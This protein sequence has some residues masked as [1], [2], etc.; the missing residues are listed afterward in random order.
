ML[1]V[2]SERAIPAV[3]LTLTVLFG[4][5]M[6][7]PAPS[8]GSG[9]S[10]TASAAAKTPIAREAVDFPQQFLLGGTNSPFFL[11]AEKGY[12][13]EAGF[14]VKV[15]PGAGSTDTVKRVQS[16]SAKFGFADVT[17]LIA[18]RSQ[19]PSI[20]VVMVAQIAQVNPLIAVYVQG[21]TIKEP[22]D[23]AG[24]AYGGF[25]GGFD[26][27]MYPGYLTKLGLDATKARFVSMD[28]AAKVPSL[29]SNQIEVFPA[30]LN[31]FPAFQ[32]AAKNANLT[33]GY[34]KFADVGLDAYSWGILTRKKTITDQPDAVKRF[35][36]AS[37]QGWIDAIKEP[38]AAV[39]AAVKLVPTLDPVVTRQ[40]LDVLIGQLIY[41]APVEKNGLGWVE[42]AT[43]DKTIDVTAEYQKLTSKPKSADVFTND[44][45]PGLIPPKR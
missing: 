14:D 8:A 1:R 28:A 32:A 39:K 2:T 27:Q 42:T 26:T 12:Y 6:C 13:G 21:R 22:K 3:L 9:A 17:S 33:L 16:G 34:F 44:Y 11:A 37:L 4:A 23:L 18:A 25:A 43:M 24:K 15:L 38:D 10:G 35:V 31:S 20:D 36:K 40:E 30:S 45:L 7:A 5:T 19:D 29:L 41:S